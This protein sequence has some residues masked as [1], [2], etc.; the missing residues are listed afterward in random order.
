MQLALAITLALQHMLFMKGIPSVIVTV[1][2]VMHNAADSNWYWFTVAT[3]VLDGSRPEKDRVVRLYVYSP[4]PSSKG[5]SVDAGEAY[6][7]VHC[8]QF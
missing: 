8:V 1:L 2:R 4:L 5:H 3:V 7:F 6:P